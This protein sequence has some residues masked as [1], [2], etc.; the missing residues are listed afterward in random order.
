MASTSNNPLADAARHIVATDTALQAR[1]RNLLDALLTEA[2]R[3]LE[4]AAPAT[5][6]AMIRTVLPAMVKESRNQEQDTKID[7][8]QAQV[9]A[10]M[11]QTRSLIGPQTIN[12]ALIP[13]DAPPT[14]AL[15]QSLGSGVNRISRP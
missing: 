6:L 7:E 1:V 8:L 10:L 9:R 2:E 14:L 12:E 13:T 11:T 3:Q 4:V 15:V 5:K